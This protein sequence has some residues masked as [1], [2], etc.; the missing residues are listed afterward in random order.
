MM[1]AVRNRPREDRVAAAYRRAQ[2][3]ADEDVEINAA[4]GR[5][6]LKLIEEI[7]AKK[8]PGAPVNVLTHCNAG[9]LATVDLATA[10]SP[11]YQPHHNPL[12]RH[13]LVHQTHP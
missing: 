11:I 10:T 5:N 4:I 9:W 6:G 12:P 8:K 3:I 2:E 1:A 13:V 7:A